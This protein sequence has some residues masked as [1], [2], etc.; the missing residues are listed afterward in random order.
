[1]QVSTGCLASMDPWA[2]QGPLVYLVNRGRLEP[3]EYLECPE[4]KDSLVYL[5]QEVKRVQQVVLAVPV[6]M[7]IQ[8]LLG[9]LEELEIQDLPVRRAL[10][11]PPV[12]IT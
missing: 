4:T 11:D 7:V 12:S 3:L 8:V 5:V 2:V 10:R 1:M 9:L 6:P